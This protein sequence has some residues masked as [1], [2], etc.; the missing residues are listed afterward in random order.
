MEP[1]NMFASFILGDPSEIPEVIQENEKLGLLYASIGKIRG[2]I[3]I[4]C[5]DRRL[6]VKKWE[7]LLREL[8]ELSQEKNR[9]VHTSLDVLSER[10]K[11]VKKIRAVSAKNKKDKDLIDLEIKERQRTNDY[12]SRLQVFIKVKSKSRYKHSI[13]PKLDQAATYESEISHIE[14]FEEVLNKLGNMLGV[15]DVEEIVK[16]FES[17]EAQINRAFE[18][19]NVQESKSSKIKEEIDRLEEEKARTI[20]ELKAS[21]DLF[22]EQILRLDEKYVGIKTETVALTKSLNKARKL[23]KHILR[24]IAFLKSIVHFD[25]DLEADLDTPASSGL[26]KTMMALEQQICQIYDLYKGLKNKSGDAMAAEVSD[27][28]SNLQ[29]DSAINEDNSTT[30]GIDDLP[31]VG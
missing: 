2:E 3:D 19:I 31:T 26:K 4:I 10:E 12:M 28:S 20:D 25:T 7:R 24:E 14:G 15:T 29:S 5:T 1:A 18:Y 22:R 11:L 27:T 23:A 13:I 16:L 21:A 9:L 8:E 6:F 30:D 17:K